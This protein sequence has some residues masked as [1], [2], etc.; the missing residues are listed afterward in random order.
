VF[1]HAG[2][3]WQGELGASRSESRRQNLDLERGLFFS[4]LYNFRPVNLAFADIQP[5]TVGRITGSRNG[6]AVS[7]LDLGTFATAGNL[8]TDITNNTGPVTTVVTSLP[9]LRVKPIFSDDKRFQING[10]VGR[11]FAFSVPTTLK[12]GFDLTDWKRDTRMDPTLGTNGGGFLYNGTDV[13]Y[14]RFLNRA[15]DR[16]L[17]LGFGVPTT[18]DSLALG[19]FFKTNRASFVQANPGVD[20]QSA[21]AN[22]KY[23]HERISAGYL[24]LDHDLLKS[25]LRLTYGL[26]YERTENDGTGPF[27]DPTRNYQRNAAGQFINAAGLPVAPGVRPALRFNNG[28]LAANQLVWIE[29]GTATR[30]SYGNYFPS[31]NASYNVTESVVARVS[32]GQTVGRPDVLNISPGYTGALDPTN[33]NPTILV[34][35]P[36]L[37][38]W[39]SR[40]IGLSLE[41]YSPSLGDITLRGY[42]RFVSNAFATLALSPAQSAEVLSLYGI[43]ANDIPSNTL[44]TTSASIPGTV[45]TSGLELSSRYSLDQILPKWAKGVQVKS[46]ATRSTLTGGGTTA[47]AFGS[48]NLYLVPYSVGLGLSYVHRFGSLALNGKWNAR[49]TLNYIDPVVSTATS[50]V[51]VVPGT[52]VY[53]DAALRVD[54]DASVRLTRRVS[55]FIN[56][57]D[58]NGYEQVTLRYAPTTPAIA[59]NASR[60]VFQPVWSFG[61]K[62]KF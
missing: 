8:S 22:S 42:R 15:Y 40:N 21:I 45:V 1:R 46:S 7:P 31:F 10:S 18:L 14:A 33:P 23:F 54:L 36:A 12:T 41:Y 2:R 58:I 17:P 27:T 59:R 34:A 3:V 56:G 11:D 4:Q 50:G 43:S 30:R 28:S 61:L 38:P 60:N 48:Q 39:T 9:P 29:R 6:V 24:R 25:R 16:A 57:R 20:W 37:E 5:W 55:F 19:E 47:A 26:R 53:N 52:Y 51:N 32:Y 62:G 35:N 44:V 49:Q 13:S